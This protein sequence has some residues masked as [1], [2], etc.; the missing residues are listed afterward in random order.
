MARAGS[1]NTGKESNMADSEQDKAKV[2][3]MIVRAWRDP[4]FK[5]RL[6]ADPHGALKEAGVAVPAGATVKAV[7]NTDKHFHLVLPPKPSGELSD[8]ALVKVA[9]GGS[10]YE[11]G[12][13]FD[14]GGIGKFHP[15]R[16]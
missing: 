3:K 8:E 11:G 2:A 6:L 1:A 4:A 14:M 16:D 13:N 15:H 10:P 5:A 9:A 12:V 7:E